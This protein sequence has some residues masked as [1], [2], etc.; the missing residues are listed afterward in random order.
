MYSW[1]G[2]K[3]LITGVNGFVGGNIAKKLIENG[4]DVFG[5]VRTC[6][7][8]T[9]LHYENIDKNISVIDGE[10]CDYELLSRVIAEEEINIIFHLAA[11][12]EVG[13][14]LKNPY[15]TFETNVRGTYTL[16]ESVRNY[17]DSVN[18]VVIAS[19]D[20]AY[21]EYAKEKMP[22]KEDYALKPEYTYDTSKACADMIAQA[23]SSNPHKLPI[24]I[25]RFSNIF[26]PGQLNFSALIPD[27]IRSAL[28]YSKFVPRGN[29]SMMRDFLYVEDVV[30]LYIKIVESFSKNKES[31]SGQIFNAGTNNPQTV[32][33]IVERIFTALDAT[34][35]YHRILHEMKNNTTVGEIDCQFMD[36]K[37]VETYFGWTPHHNTEEGISK[38]IEWF[39]KYLKDRYI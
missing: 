12:V 4:A 17:P 9:F 38:T 21:G 22:Y 23:Y 32:K 39:K 28:G 20:K 15:I 19:S 37:K 34:D 35:E 3:V 24:V 2:V 29:G 18:A 16:L 27:A 1:N 30:D 14:G 33:N 8:N 11:Q 7:Y 26:G 6:K 5:L 10:L 13:V 36:Y 25:T 31:I